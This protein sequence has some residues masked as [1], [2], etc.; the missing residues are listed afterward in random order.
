MN[1]Q[2]NVWIALIVI[3]LV[4]IFALAYKGKLF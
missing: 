1:Q 4:V 2:K 3:F